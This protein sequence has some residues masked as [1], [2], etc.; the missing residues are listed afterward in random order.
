M[1]PIIVGGKK[2]A[3]CASFKTQKKGFFSDLF[4]SLTS[5]SSPQK[6]THRR[7]QSR[8]RKSRRRSA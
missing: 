3:G 2:R 6:K 4:G 8:K 5:S 7:R 1:S